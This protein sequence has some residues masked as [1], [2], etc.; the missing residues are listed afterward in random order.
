MN[1]ND[2]SGN[3]AEIEIVPRRYSFKS[4]S[5]Q[6]SLVHEVDYEESKNENDSPGKSHIKSSPKESCVKSS[7]NNEKIM[8][9][10]QKASEKSSENF[11]DYDFERK[12]EEEKAP[13]E[14]DNPPKETDSHFSPL[15]ELQGKDKKSEESDSGDLDDLEEENHALKLREEPSYKDH[16]TLIFPDDTFKEQWEMILAVMILYSCLWVPYYMAFVD[17]EGLPTVIMDGFSD[18][19]FLVDVV[20]NFNSAFFDDQDVLIVERPQIALAYLRLWFWLDLTSA[21]PFSL[22]TQF[23][24]S[25]KSLKFQKLIKLTRF[26]RIF[27]MIKERNRILKYLNSLLKITAGGA[28]NILGP[29]VVMACFCHVCACFYYMMVLAEDLPDTWIVNYHDSPDNEKYLAS[30]YWVT[31][32]VVTTGY[33]DVPCITTLERLFAICLMF[34]GVLVYSF[35]VGSLSNFLITLDEQNEAFNEKLMSLYSMKHRYSLDFFLCKRIERFLRYG[36]KIQIR[37]EQ[38]SFVLELPKNLKIELSAIIYK[39]LIDGVEFFTNK[40]K[41]FMAFVCPYLKSIK[42]KKDDI[43]ADEGDRANEIYFLKSGSVA[44]V[45]KQYDNFKFMKIAQGNYFGEVIFGIF[46][47]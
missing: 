20:V 6:L 2:P 45:L 14:N 34:I 10:S 40:P 5:R 22:I 31:Q 47:L 41:R 21:L 42:F 11:V 3:S 7:E 37:E 39:N 1:S 19:I 12:S 43:V 36:K 8:R 28:E 30:F 23:A 9:Q 16:K 4:D 24:G 44:L 26:L 46:F 27:K 18:L 32:T 35:S 15:V 38:K 13:E 25:N 33:G 17:Q 29:I